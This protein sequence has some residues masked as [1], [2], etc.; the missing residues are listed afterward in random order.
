MD[1]LDDLLLF[2]HEA[3]K[4]ITELQDQVW[5]LQGEIRDIQGWIHALIKISVTPENA[6]E[7]LDEAL[8]RT[9][10]IVKFTV[11]TLQNGEIV[12]EARAFLVKGG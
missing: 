7:F 2:K 8:V 12:Y 11:A 5:R 10:R 3:V 6:L 9:K 1:L 4:R